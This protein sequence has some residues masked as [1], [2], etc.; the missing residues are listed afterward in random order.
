MHFLLKDE[1]TFPDLSQVPIYD[2][3][4]ER[5]S[6]PSGVILSMRKNLYPKPL[7]VKPN[8]RNEIDTEFFKSHCY[9]RALMESKYRSEIQQ[10]MRLPEDDKNVTW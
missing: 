10:A 8:L 1:L 4:F 5:V 7:N 6:D 3:H 2:C 9:T